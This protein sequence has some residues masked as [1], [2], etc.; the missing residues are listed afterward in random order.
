MYV[1]TLHGWF[2]KDFKPE[3]AIH[4]VIHLSGGAFKE[5]LAK[6]ILFPK[7]FSAELFDL[8]E[9][10]KIMRQCAQW[11]K[12]TDEEFYE[13]WHGGQGMLLIVEEKDASHCLKRAK[14]FGIKAK[15]AGRITKEKNPQ[16]SINSKL[17]KGKIIIYK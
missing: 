12:I 5:K 8:W 15:I 6:D 2:N 4:S 11:R 9:P 7:K 16:V 17:T 1:N 13:V 3:I 14:D 10:P